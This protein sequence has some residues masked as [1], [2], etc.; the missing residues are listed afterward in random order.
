MR[1][2]D[3]VRDAVR[4]SVSD[5]AASWLEQALDT[6]RRGSQEQLLQLYTSVAA[7]LG[8]H[9]LTGLPGRLPDGMTDATF[10][11]WTVAD[12]ARAA[13]LIARAEQVAPDAFAADAAACYENGDA[14]EQRSWLRAVAVLPQPAQFLPLVI[15]ACRTNILPNF[16]AVACE[17]VYPSEYVP[18]R[19]FNQ[20]ILKA[21]FNNVAL[22]R[23][24]GLARRANPELTRMAGDYAAERR[25]AGRTVP[26]DISLAMTG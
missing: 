22:T 19:N 8:N 20:L 11:S 23:I 6:T 14:A 3:F 17:N 18:E 15:D 4:A 2:G 26:A 25:A 13:L 16:E 24:V 1:T 12:S 5:A 21:L 10:A 9:P 7:R